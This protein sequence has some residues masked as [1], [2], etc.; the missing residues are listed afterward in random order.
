MEEI[1]KSVKD[2]EGIYEISNLG[3]LRSI[4]RIAKSFDGAYDKI[5][6][7]KIKKQSDDGTGY[8]IVALW[9]NNKQKMKRIYCLVAEENC[10]DAEICISN[11]I[12]LD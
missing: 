7:G 2:F 3:N 8:C 10:Y 9:K 11:P 1:W 4:D 12:K 6:K 5:V